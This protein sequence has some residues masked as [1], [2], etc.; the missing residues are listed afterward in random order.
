VGAGKVT[1]HLVGSPPAIKG[2]PARKLVSDYLD[3]M[4][5]LIVDA[6]Q[7]FIAEAADS[8]VGVRTGDR[9]D[10]GN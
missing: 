10:R 6:K 5:A 7:K 4:E 2:K 9:A 1:V 8:R 3:K